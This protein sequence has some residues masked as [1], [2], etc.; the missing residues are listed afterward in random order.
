MTV[1]IPNLFHGPYKG[2][3]VDLIDGPTPFT[4]A[5]KLQVFLHERNARV[6]ATCIVDQSALLATSPNGVYTVDEC[7]QR[8]KDHR[9]ALIVTW[10]PA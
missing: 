6:I 1:F 8:V 2:Q 5:D 3:S 10:E 7:D 4:C 9:Y